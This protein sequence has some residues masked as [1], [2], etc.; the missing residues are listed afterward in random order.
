[1]IYPPPGRPPMPHRLSPYRTRPGREPGRR[2]APPQQEGRGNDMSRRLVINLTG[3]PPAERRG[4][5]RPPSR[6]SSGGVRTLR[7]LQ[8]NDNTDNTTPQGV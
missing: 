6:P 1:M 4:R 7:R 3:H 2:K 5:A 8:Q